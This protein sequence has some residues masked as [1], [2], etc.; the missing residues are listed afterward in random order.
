MDFTLNDEQRMFSETARQLFANT[1]TPEDWRRQMES[2][3]PIEADRW[4]AIAET[5][6]TGVLLP[7]DAGGLGL[8]ELD[9]AMIAE[10][11]GYYALPDPLIESAGIA[12]PLLAAAMPDAKV[13]SDPSAI[14][15][16]AHPINP[17]VSDAEAAQVIVA[18]KDGDSWLVERDDARLTRRQSIDPF[19]HLYSLDFDTLK[20][21]QLPE[22]DW[23]IAL[24]RGALFA[25]AQGLGLA[26]R[27][28]DLAVEY[29]K[30]RQQFGKP[31]GTY[32]AVKHHLASAQ[33]AIEFARPVVLAAAADFAAGDR[34]SRA[35]ISHAKIVAL[36]AAD[37]AART[38]IQVH[39]AMGYS[40]EV[41][42]HLFLKRALALTNS[43][44]TPV[45]HRRRIMARIKS[46]PLGP[47]RTFARD[48]VEA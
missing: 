46:E 7:E 5:G 4:A 27:A 21:V 29:A 42:V 32:Q 13:L 44:G 28:V 11:A 14:V 25:A 30:Q 47:D 19:R 2:G 15:A 35:R 17:L 16:I 3:S 31:I 37:A 45:F 23:D 24:D 36:E 26:Q 38:S 33:V 41:D 40:W 12:A 20:A 10:A 9:F 8:T 48:G 34:H 22:T 39:G 43:W 18:T 1:C 6:L